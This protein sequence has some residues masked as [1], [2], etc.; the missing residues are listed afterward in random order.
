[1]HQN[2]QNSDSEPTEHQK[3]ASVFIQA[4][5]RILHVI[6]RLLVRRGVGMVTVAEVAKRAMVKGAADVAQEQGL[7][8]T[9]R[10]LAVYTGLPH[11]EVERQCKSIEAS[12]DLS[13]PKFLAIT[14]LLTTWHLDRR[15]VLTNHLVEVPLE[16]SF[17]SNDSL[18][19]KRLVEECAPE[20]DAKELLEELVRTNHV[21]INPDTGFL[22]PT[23]RFYI[24]EPFEATDSERF[25]RMVPAYLTT[26]EIN[27]RKEGPGKG[28]FERHVS[29]DFPISPEDEKRFAD[30][31]RELGKKSLLDLDEFLAELKPV[32]ENG[33]RVGTVIFYYVMTDGSASPGGPEETSNKNDGEDPGVETEGSADDDSSVID[34]LNFKKPRGRK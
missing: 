23:T 19:F 17:E 30:K 15:Y 31:V 26:L 14:R 29:A 9:T 22:H 18:S 5:E 3:R 34:T 12:V 8:G 24:P 28:H 16:L 4:V 13:E 1:L 11:R 6:F 2:K 7:P 25:G 10:R 33:R 21:A 20:L 32:P 27:S